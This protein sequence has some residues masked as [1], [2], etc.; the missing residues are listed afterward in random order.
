MPKGTDRPKRKKLNSVEKKG[1]KAIAIQLYVKQA[2]RKAQKR[3]EPNDRRY[4]HE[5]QKAV[6]LMKPDEF[7]ELTHIDKED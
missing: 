6:G 7:Y 1:R 5:I 3:I 2:G 4:S